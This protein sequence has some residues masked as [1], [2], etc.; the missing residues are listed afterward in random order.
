VA[1]LE[2]VMRLGNV[3]I[4]EERTISYNRGE[5]IRNKKKCPVVTV[6]GKIAATLTSIGIDCV[7]VSFS[8]MNKT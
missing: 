1:H 5:S 4:I 6:S 3:R 7:A 8:I 2:Y